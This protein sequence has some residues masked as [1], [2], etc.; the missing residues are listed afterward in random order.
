MTKDRFGIKKWARWL[1]TFVGFPLAGVAA[2]LV[3]GNIDD[4]GSAA[5]GGLA[6]GAVLGAVQ[7]IVGGLDRRDWVPW[8]GATAGGLAVGL[9]VGSRAVGFHTD[10]ASLMI[11]GAISGACVGIAQ[12]GSV[13]MRMI[14][15]ILWAA[16]TPLLWTGAWLITLQVIVDPERQHA[17]FGASGA[18]GASALAGV[19]YAIRRPS[20]DATGV[21]RAAA[22]SAVA[23]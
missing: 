9:T 1:G 10:T 18:V 22:G 19:L 20:T 11:M 13:R 17:L 6:A 2:R 15:R 21:V 5:L 4:T 7:A 14:D 16:A 23:R 12:A 8:I 3:A